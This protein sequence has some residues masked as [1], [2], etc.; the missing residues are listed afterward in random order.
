MGPRYN[1]PPKC[2]HCRNGKVYCGEA[3]EP[4]ECGECGGLGYLEYKWNWP[5]ILIALGVLVFWVAFGAFVL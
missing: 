3:L 1:P 5:V 4:L 2:P